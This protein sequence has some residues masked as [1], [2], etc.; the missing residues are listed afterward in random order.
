MPGKCQRHQAEAGG[1]KRWQEEDER[2]GIGLR[3]VQVAA[4]L[5]AKRG[6]GID[7]AQGGQQPAAPGRSD[8]QVKNGKRATIAVPLPGVRTHRGK[9]ASCPSIFKGISQMK[10][11]YSVTLRRR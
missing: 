6:Q 3:Q 5:Q 7:Q 1:K 2:L 9:P 11:Y 10:Y 8:V 4:R